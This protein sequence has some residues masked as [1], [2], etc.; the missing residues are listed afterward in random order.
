VGREFLAA[1]LLTLFLLAGCTTKSKANARARE[2][3]L[4]GQQQGI[5]QVNEARRINIRFVG[6]VRHPEVRWEDGLTLIQAI[7]AAE[8][9]D[10]RDP[11]II[12]IIRQSERVAVSPRELLAGRDVPLAPGDTVE[13]HP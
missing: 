2:A 1:V 5:A 13:I 3:F 7:A 8:Y 12:L 11:R 10:A 9:T 4:A 6:P